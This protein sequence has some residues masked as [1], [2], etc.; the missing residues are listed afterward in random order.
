M[1]GAA[2]GFSFT[3][4]SAGLACV[5]CLACLACVAL[6]SLFCTLLVTATASASEPAQVAAQSGAGQ[7]SAGCGDRGAPL[8]AGRALVG[9]LTQGSVTG[10]YLLTTPRPYNRT[11]AYRLVLLFYGFASN[12]AQFSSLTDMPT[13]GAAAGD[14]VVVPHTSGTESEWQFSGTGSDAAFVNALVGHLESVYCVDQRAV[15]A[16]GFSAGAAFSIIYGCSHQSQIA[17]LATVAVEYQLGCTAPMPILDFHGT[18]DPEVP[19]QNGAIGLS[20]PGVKVRGTQLNMGDWARLDHCR[21]AARSTK[22]SSQVRLQRWTGCTRGAS[23]T[24]YTVV[25]GSHTWP[26]ADPKKGVGLTT[27]QVSATAKILAF[28]TA[29]RPEA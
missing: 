6:V 18:R 21:T 29:I 27:R 12:P 26:S 24:L 10:T 4:R 16:T 17:A 2:R 28:F 1:P 7:R 20:F 23:V 3:L 8:S 14:I 22:V 15:F 25:G 13:R 9:S 19:Y 11:H 5:A